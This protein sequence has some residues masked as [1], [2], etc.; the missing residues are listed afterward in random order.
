MWKGQGGG[1]IKRGGGFEDRKEGDKT[2][3]PEEASLKVRV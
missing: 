1:K 2:R 3:T